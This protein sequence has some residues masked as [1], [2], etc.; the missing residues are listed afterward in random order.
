MCTRA[1]RRKGRLK[2]AVVEFA[3][4]ER[5]FGDG[6]NETLLNKAVTTVI[7]RIRKCRQQVAARATGAGDLGRAPWPRMIPRVAV[8]R[9]ARAR[10]NRQAWR[11]DALAYDD[12]CFVCF[13][14]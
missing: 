3:V 4:W 6:G 11:A 12:F 10:A 7:V 5:E 13:G 8:L 2:P 9:P 1:R 14:C